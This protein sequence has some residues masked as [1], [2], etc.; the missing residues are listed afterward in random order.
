ML[1]ILNPHD[2]NVQYEIEIKSKDVF[3]KTLKDADLL[4]NPF[5]PPVRLLNQWYDMLQSGIFILSPKHL[6]TSIRNRM[7]N[8][9]KQDIVKAILK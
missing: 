7:E 3:I 1:L 6:K 9:K 5:E 2:E 4:V 8:T